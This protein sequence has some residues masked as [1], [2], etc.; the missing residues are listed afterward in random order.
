[1]LAG[2]RTFTVERAEGPVPVEIRL[3]LPEPFESMPA[4]RSTGPKAK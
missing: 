2:V 1:M 3:Y 4:T